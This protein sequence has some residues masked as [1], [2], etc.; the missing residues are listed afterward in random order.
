MQ[1]HVHITF[2]SYR[3]DFLDEIFQILPKAL[4]AQNLICPNQ[5]L[6]FLREIRG[7]PAGQGH[8]CRIHPVHILFIVNKRIRTIR[9]R[10]IQPGSRPVKNRHK[11]I[12]DAPY[13]LCRQPADIFLIILYIF[14]VF[15]PVQ[16]DI[17][18][19]RDAFY[20]FQRKAGAADFFFQF[21]DGLN[22]PDF[23]YGDV[24]YS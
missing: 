14:L 20:H 19:H 2:Y 13:P 1:P 11:I 21:P 8:L 23:T 6:Y 10:L 18:M 5:L 24:I 4:N 9:Q 7:I 15:S 17:L 16:L 3:N 12:A 22:R